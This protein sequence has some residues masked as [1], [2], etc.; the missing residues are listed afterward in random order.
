MEIKKGNINLKEQVACANQSVLVEGDIIVG[1]N[2]P[3]VA[4]ILCAD[5]KVKIID[6]EYKNGKAIAYGNV[7]FEALYMPDSENTELK[8]M[9]HNFE[10]STSVDIRGDENTEFIADA[11]AEHIGFTLVNSR[12]MSAKVMVAVK[13]CAYCDKCYE[14]ITE[15]CSDNIEFTEKKH[16]IYIPMSEVCT[17]IEVNDLLTVPEDMADISEILKVDTWVKPG[18]VRVMSGKAMVQGELHLN[19]LYTSA[20]ERGSVLSVSHTVPFTEIIEAPGADEQSVVNVSFK[21]LEV[22]ANIKGDLNGDTKIISMESVICACA[23]VSK[24]IAET[25]VD[26]CY[27][28]TGKTEVQKETMNICEYITSE[29]ARITERHVPQIPKNVSVKEIISCNAKPVLKECNWDN[30]IARV[31]GILITYLIYRDEADRVRCCVTESELN[32]EKAISEPCNID[33]SLNL[34]SVSASVD[35]GNVQIL[36]NTGIYMKALKNK[37]VNILTS[38]EEKEEEKT[39]TRPTMVVYFA[40]DG[41]TVWDIAKKYRTK[42]EKIKIANNLETEKVE[43]GRRLLIPIA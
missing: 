12:K 10:F 24:T 38:C 21:V 6:T 33:A 30:G 8:S 22:L 29:N 41:D 27:F 9:S 39:T 42:T 35:G 37:N 16:S 4:E 7:E 15:I 19:T 13:I 1:D 36:S 40:K 2:A 26:D 43:K 34:E 5:A 20:D 28:L 17:D 11:C 32:W 14:P 23:K 25:T 31:L 18:D 3:D